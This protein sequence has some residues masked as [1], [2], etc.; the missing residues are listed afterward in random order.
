MRRLDAHVG[1][2]ETLHRRCRAR[3]QEPSG[4]DPQRQRDDRGRQRSRPT[5]AASCGVIEQ[6]VARMER[7]LSGVRE[8]TAIDARLVTRA[9]EE[10]DLGALLTKIVDGFRLREGERVRFQLDAGPGPLT[11]DA[12]EDRLTQVFENLLDNAL[13]FSPPGSTVIVTVAPMGAEDGRSGHAHR[14][15]GAG[16]PGRQHRPAS[17]TAS[18]RI[19]PT[20]PRHDSGGHTG[21]GLAIVRTIVE[22]YGGAIGAANAERGA[23]FTVR[24]PRRGARARWSRFGF[25]AFFRHLSSCALRGERVRWRPRIAGTPA[26][27]PRGPVNRTEMSE[28][29]Q[30]PALPEVTVYPSI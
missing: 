26:V 28:L 11:V 2:I 6:E 27:R 13:S 5:G 1:Y 7:L 24:L 17:S 18:S 3:A 8:I 21:L 9:P 29:Q 10:V 15:H 12:T 30:R 14:R 4:L 25:H 22:G 16:H 23:V 19:V 20:L